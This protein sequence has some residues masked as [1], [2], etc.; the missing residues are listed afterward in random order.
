M[1]DPPWLG[2]PPPKLSVTK[3]AALW[4]RVCVVIIVETPPPLA[5]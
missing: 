4:S 1:A 3:W 2:Y 5:G